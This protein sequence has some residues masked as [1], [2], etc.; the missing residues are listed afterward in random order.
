M[1]LRLLLLLPWAA[2][3]VKIPTVEIAKGVQMPVM[4]I[5]IGGLE[6]SNASE[7]VANW[8]NQGGR[9]IDTA[10]IYQDQQV[11]PEESDYID[12]LLIH[13][14]I[15]DCP[16]AW[17]ILEDY[18]R[19][20]VLRA[21]G[22]SNFN[23]SQVD[24]DETEGIRRA[25]VA[26]ERSKQLNITVEAY[27]PVG[28]SGH[29]GDIRDNQVIKSIA[30][31]HSV[32]TY[33]DAPTE[34][35]VTPLEAWQALQGSQVSVMMTEELREKAK[36]AFQREEVVFLHHVVAVAFPALPT[37]NAA[38]K[39]LRQGRVLVDGVVKKQHDALAPVPGSILLAHLGAVDSILPQVEG[40]RLV[41]RNILSTRVGCTGLL[42]AWNSKS[43]RPEARIY[44][45]QSDP[46][47]GWA[48]VNKPCGMHC[49]PCGF[50]TGLVT[51]EGYLPA[52]VE[53]PLTGTHCRCPRVCHR[54]DFRVCGPVLVATAEETMRRLKASFEHRKVKKEY[55]AIVCGR[56]GEPGSHWSISAPVEGA[57]ATTEIQVLSVV[58][59]PH[60]DFLSELKLIPV[61]GR[62][63]QLRQHCAL[64]L[65]AP[66]VNEERPLFQAAAEAWQRR[67]GSAL[68]PYHVRGGAAVEW[69]PLNCSSLGE[70][71]LEELLA[72]FSP[73]HLHEFAESAQ[74]P[75]PPAVLF[76]RGRVIAATPAWRRFMSV[77]RALLVAMANGVGPSAFGEAARSLTLEEVD[78]L[79]VR[80]RASGDSST[81]ELQHQMLS[82]RLYPDQRYIPPELHESIGDARQRED[83]S[84]V[85]SVLAPVQVC[86]DLRITLPRLRENA[87]DCAKQGSLPFLW[88]KLLGRTEEPL[89][90]LGKLS[91]AI[92]LDENSG[93]VVAFP[94]L[95]SRSKNVGEISTGL[96]RTVYWF[97]VLP[98]LSAS[99]LILQPPHEEVRFQ[100]LA[101]HLRSGQLVAFPTET[102]YGLGA[103]GLDP[104][105]VLKIFSA[106]GR[107][108]ILALGFGQVLE[109]IYAL[110]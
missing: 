38:R 99:S 13:D 28:R 33:Q 61:T 82:L 86:K 34:T 59:C 32:S 18:H 57:D 89:L 2:C 48:V 35:G 25:G 16:K 66:I 100:H 7:I 4:S 12:L 15:G 107:R 10:L 37:L 6:R 26:L 95:T 94:A 68:P 105:A 17:S 41:P 106:K 52:L 3:E 14:P 58:R 22:I 87:L 50:N 69:L 67:T 88:Q 5:G 75:R 108:Q 30:A 110:H 27:S 65:G 40:G 29:S 71:A 93:D 31:K 64:L 20:G 96:R 55:R 60:F 97:H 42:Q 45:I 44:L 23:A 21:I 72:H 84:L 56:V 36:I 63:H 78:D 8:I 98:P 9:G 104:E 85:L 47:A 1:L 80:F 70:H 49:K 92:L 109:V 83:A 73:E 39:A 43:E 81:E 54:L 53:P 90:R 19:Q 74:P 11:V 102:V 51:L 46:V 62:H 103:N 101:R 77:D 24:R 91:V 76:W 79:W